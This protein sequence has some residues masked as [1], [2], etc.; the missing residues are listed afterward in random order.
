MGTGLVDETIH[1]D[2]CTTF[3]NVLKTTDLDNLNQ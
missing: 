2:G 3:V 1:G